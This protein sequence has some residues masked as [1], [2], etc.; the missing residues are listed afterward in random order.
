MNKEL[1]WA[2]AELTNVQQQFIERRLR[3]ANVINGK[4][5]YTDKKNIEK[6]MRD[7]TNAYGGQFSSIMG[8]VD[9]EESTQYLSNIDITLSDT[10]GSIISGFLGVL[11]VM[12]KKGGQRYKSRLSSE[13][14]AMEAPTEVKYGVQDSVIPS[15]GKSRV[16]PV[17]DS[18]IKT[19]PL[20]D[21]ITAPLGKIFD[22][23]SKNKSLSYQSIKEQLRYMK[24]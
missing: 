7:A 24:T 5:Y 6:Q 13:L 11:E 4:S 22:N 17:Q 19:N 18:F 21:I 15:N 20:D 10:R 3:Q 12:D 1:K 14:S 8:M 2:S 9:A 23:V 16:I